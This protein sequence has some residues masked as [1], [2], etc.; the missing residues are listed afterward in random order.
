[1]QHWLHIYA[2]GITILSL[3]VYYVTLLQHKGIHNYKHNSHLS[4]LKQGMVFVTRFLFINY[5]NVL[6]SIIYTLKVHIEGTVATRLWLV[7]LV[8]L[9]QSSHFE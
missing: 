8:C 3:S 7:F 5:Y 6:V 9:L 1:M 4:H 2:V